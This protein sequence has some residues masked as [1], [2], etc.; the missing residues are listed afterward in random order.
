MITQQEYTTILTAKL[1]QLQ[2]DLQAIAQFNQH[3]G[4]W[5][6]VPDTETQADADENANADGVEEWN[7][8][9][10]TV[11]ALET[12]YRD[13]TRALE[14]LATNTFG[15]CE[16]CGQSIEVGRLTIRPTARTCTL[17]QAEEFELSL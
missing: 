9:C 10:A 11:A 12:E 17:H 14:K 8:R 7:E 3:T 15:S 2:T 5:E 4:D 16:I 6:A 1:E 13:T